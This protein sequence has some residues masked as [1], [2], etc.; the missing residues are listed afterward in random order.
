MWNSVR[1]PSI[2]L[3]QI[4]IPQS[5][6]KSLS[7]ML[8]G[9]PLHMGRPSVS[10][11]RLKRG[12]RKEH[13]PLLICPVLFLWNDRKRLNWRAGVNATHLIRSAAN[14]PPSGKLHGVMRYR[15]LSNPLHTFCDFLGFLSSAPFACKTIYRSLVSG[16]VCEKPLPYTWIPI[17]VVWNV[18]QE[19]DRMIPNT[20]EH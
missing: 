4:R 6:N 20:S 15:S 14:K 8:E 5:R 11:L 16:I 17:L 1:L 9:L 12:I 2:I 18:R 10:L 7:M 3:P 13:S 19:G